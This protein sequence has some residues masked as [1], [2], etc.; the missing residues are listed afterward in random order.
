MQVLR[1]FGA[2]LLWNIAASLAL[3]LLPPLIGL[4]IA[5]LLAGVLL[6]GYLLR[7]DEPGAHQTLLRLNPLRGARL[8]WTLASLPVF[9]VFNWA[10]G[11]IYIRLVPVPPENFDPFAGLMSDAEG[12][13]AITTLAVAMAPLLEEF[14]FRGFVQGS[15]ER[16]LGV[17]TG[18]GVTALLFALIHF[19]PWLLPLHLFL[20][21]SFGYAVYATGS[22]WAGVMLHAANNAAAMLGSGVQ[23]EPA[24]VSPTLWTTGPTSEWWSS[25]FAAV[26]SGAVLGVLAYRLWKARPESGLRHVRADG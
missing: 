1:Y 14:V 24:T 17:A 22:V 25:V 10:L 6:W 13:L 18:I 9:L 26:A 8:R 12:R 16:R 19:R 23:D 21:V 4:A 5:M 3:M 15:L 7:S 11:E 2:F 20:G